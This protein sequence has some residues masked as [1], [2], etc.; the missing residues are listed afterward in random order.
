MKTLN[1]REAAVFLPLHP[2]DLRT[3]AKPGFTPGA[4]ISRSWGF[5]D[6]AVAALIRTQYSVWRQAR[7]GDLALKN[8]DRFTGSSLQT[9]Q[10]YYKL[11]GLKLRHS[12]LAQ[13]RPKSGSGVPQMSA[14]QSP[15]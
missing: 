9:M 12:T 11:P 15:F 7:W 1:L 14:V 10:E 3:R 5:I 8:A 2:E 13:A 6:D 4:K